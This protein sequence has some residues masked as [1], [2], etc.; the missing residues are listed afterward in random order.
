MTSRF[1]HILSP[2]DFTEK[3][4]PA[5]DVVLEMA[6][7]NGA[8]VTLLHVIERVE[9]AEDEEIR[10]FYTVLEEKA[11]ANLAAMTQRF[12]EEGIVVEQGIVFGRRGPEIVRYSIEHQAD[13]I[14]LSSHKIDPTH[15]AEDWATLSYQVSIL[16]PCHVLLVK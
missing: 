10:E 2:V 5:L 12:V 3:N 15:V 7:Q 11:R 14:V 16:C 1:K 9:Y 4:R 13:L 6:Q 8:R